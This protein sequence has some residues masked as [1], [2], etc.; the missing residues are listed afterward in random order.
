MRRLLYDGKKNLNR[1]CSNIIYHWLDFLIFV[2]EDLFSGACERIG[3]HFSRPIIL[4]INEF[5]LS[6]KVNME[7]K[8]SGKIPQLIQ[9]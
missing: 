9:G 3:C 4:Q 7:S 5:S 1:S 6:R 2:F 8:Y